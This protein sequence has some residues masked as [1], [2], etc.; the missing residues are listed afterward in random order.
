MPVTI[1]QW[2]DKAIMMDRQWEVA[3]TEE[4]FY[5]KVNGTVRKLL[6]HGQQGQGQGQGQAL[7][8]QQGYQQHFF[9]N[10]TPPQH[11]QL[12]RD[13]NAMDVDRNQA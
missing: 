3:R 9:R 13:S 10:Q 7:S 4:S 12:Q 1:G 11:G 5:G 2:Y 8:L 6:Q